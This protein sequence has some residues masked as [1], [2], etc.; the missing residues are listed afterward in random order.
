[1]LYFIAEDLCTA[2]KLTRLAFTDLFTTKANC[3]VVSVYVH[4]FQSMVVAPK[5]YVWSTAVSFLILRT[6]G[7]WQDLPYG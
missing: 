2:D 6:K 5:K 7:R 4:Y 1:M 3:V